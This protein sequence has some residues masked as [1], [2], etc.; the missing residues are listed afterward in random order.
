MKCKS[1]R[2]RF[3]LRKPVERIGTVKRAYL[4]TTEN[5]QSGIRPYSS[6][7]GT[8][9]GLVI[10]LN[11]GNESPATFELPEFVQLSFREGIF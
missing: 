4:A 9:P 11:F 8:A 1:R 6:C 7:F 2:G 10:A 5:T 3:R